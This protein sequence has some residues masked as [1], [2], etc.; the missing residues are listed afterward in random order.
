M[1]KIMIEEKIHCPEGNIY[2]IMS[3]DDELGYNIDVTGEDGI[4]GDLVE[5][6]N[7]SFGYEVWSRT[8]CLNWFQVV[9]KEITEI[10]AQPDSTK[11]IYA[12]I[13]NYDCMYDI[14][15]EGHLKDLGKIFQAIR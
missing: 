5:M 14:D 3:D 7:W 6:G 1:G 12:F 11:S 8:T 4:D 15:E 13:D 10:C 9:V 2:I